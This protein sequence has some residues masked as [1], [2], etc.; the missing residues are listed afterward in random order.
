MYSA[1]DA[2][3]GSSARHCSKHT[4]RSVGILLSS[5]WLAQSPHQCCLR[6]AEA[7]AVE[8][9][10]ANLELVAESNVD[11]AD[12]TVSLRFTRWV[13][14]LAPF[15]SILPDA[16]DSTA[17][18]ICLVYIKSF[19]MC[20][21]RDPTWASVLPRIGVL[22]RTLLL[23]P[24]GLWLDLEPLGLRSLNACSGAFGSSA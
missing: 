23:L 24:L 1:S 21:S 7:S 22:V 12:L 2:C 8:V 10:D 3:D 19:V 16:H 14:Q 11:I 6:G 18:K 9:L 17:C 13:N 5:L 20:E 15:S 4:R